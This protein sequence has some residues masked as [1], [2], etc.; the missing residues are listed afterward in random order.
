MTFTIPRLSLTLG[1][2]L[3]A[4]LSQ[5]LLAQ[6]TIEE[7]LDKLEKEN[8]ELRN[9]MDAVSGELEIFE[10]RDI[11][12]KVGES[13]SGLGP[14]ASKVYQKESG[15]SIGG[16]GEMVYTDYS[17]S[18]TSTA[19]FVRNVLY[20]GYK[21]DD[22]WV[23]NS[24]IEVE[25]ADEIFLEF[26]YLEYMHNDAFN[27]RTG[28][29]LMPMGLHNEMHEPTT[30]RGPGRP[31]TERRIIPSTWRENGLGVLGDVGDFSYKFYI[32]NGMDASGFDEKGL[33]GGRQKGSKALAEDLAAVA[34]FDWNSDFGLFA[35]F[36][37]YYGD[38][39]QEQAGYASSGTTIY[40]LHAQYSVGALRLRGLYAMSDL[41]DADAISMTNGNKV[42]S[43]MDGWYLEAGYDIASAINPDSTHSVIPFVRYEEINTQA[44]MPAGLTADPFYDEKI[45]TMGIDW[46]PIANI[47]LKAAYLDYDN[48]DDSMQ[49]SMGY[50][51]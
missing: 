28:M 3:F 23:F 8:K 51:F 11:I 16:Y 50:V 33:R 20:I 38:S 41:E 17:G 14:A 44:K 49:L 40:D 19:D 4:P 34:R 29:L 39:G 10:F 48:D 12:P 37:A 1:A 25:H 6:D 5:A 2:A 15:L 9:Q 47:V 21:F 13:V 35:G 43:E 30:Y 36:S 26:A 32:V 42:A 45:T 46:K 24:E 27:F 7:R 18:K 31:E 22:K